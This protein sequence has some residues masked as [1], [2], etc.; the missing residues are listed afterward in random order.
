MCRE[1][2]FQY[3]VWS[4]YSVNSFKPGNMDSLDPDSVA[5]DLVLRSDAAL[6]RRESTNNEVHM[7][8]S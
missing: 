7:F 1:E 3:R 4:V 8:G 6:L 2:T 5:K